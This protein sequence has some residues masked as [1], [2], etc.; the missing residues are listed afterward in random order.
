MVE[1]GAPWG[2]ITMTRI[3]LRS[4]NTYRTMRVPGTVGTRHNN[5]STTTTNYRGMR[6]TRTFPRLPYIFPLF[7]LPLTGAGFGA[8]YCY[9]SWSILRSFHGSSHRRHSSSKTSSVIQRTRLVDCW[10]A[11]KNASARSG[12][13]TQ[14]SSWPLSHSLI[15][16]LC[17]GRR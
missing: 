2:I 17:T 13:T 10:A 4:R 16:G 8:L 3:T 9:I 11:A 1:R 14:G 12:R 5:P 6:D 7:L 15:N